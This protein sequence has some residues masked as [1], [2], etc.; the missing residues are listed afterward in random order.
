MSIRR[1]CRVGLLVSYKRHENWWEHEAVGDGNGQTSKCH[2]HQVMSNLFRGVSTLQ[3]VL[4]ECPSKRWVGRSRVHLDEARQ[5]QRP[6]RLAYKGDEATD[7][8]STVSV[9]PETINGCQ[10]HGQFTIEADKTA[11]VLLVWN[12][13][14]I[15]RL[16]AE[17]RKH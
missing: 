4:K 3:F 16:A 10:W 13:I 9:C 5:R 1:F 12:R 6:V 8:Y 17:R 15:D 7:E 11:H 2:S 14:V